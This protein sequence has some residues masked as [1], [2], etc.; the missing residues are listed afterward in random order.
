M[1]TQFASKGRARVFATDNILSL[2]MCSTRS[3][4][5]WDIVIVREGDKLYFDKRDTEEGPFGVLGPH[6]RA[7]RARACKVPAD[8]VLASTPIRY[9]LRQRERC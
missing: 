4:Y 8:V 2:L 5:P 3:V 6:L 1:L 7:K 9:R